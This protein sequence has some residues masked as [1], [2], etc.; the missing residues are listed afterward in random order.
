MIPAS[1][2]NRL[3]YVPPL[4]ASTTDDSAVSVGYSKIFYL[5]ISQLKILYIHDKLP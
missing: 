1:F 3:V 2:K 4:P 5:L